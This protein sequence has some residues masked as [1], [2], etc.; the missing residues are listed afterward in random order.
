MH[1]TLRFLVE[2]GDIIPS[3]S[4]LENFDLRKWLLSSPKKPAD[5]GSFR[6][7]VSGKENSVEFFMPECLGTKIPWNFSCWSVWEQKFHGIFHAGVSG[8]KNSMEFF[9]LE[10]LG[11]KIPWNSILH[12][13][14]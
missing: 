9:V 6:A 13:I 7:G 12:F 8:N 2:K 5:N 10:C 1:K 3:L 11:T 4:K 14:H